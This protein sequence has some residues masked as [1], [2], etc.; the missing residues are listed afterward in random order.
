[1]IGLIRSVR[2]EMTVPPKTR[3]EL[4]CWDP[5]PALRRWIDTWEG[6]F[7]RLANVDPISVAASDGAREKVSQGSIQLFDGASEYWL[8]LAGIIDIPAER[9]RLSGVRDKVLAEAQK[10]AR[11]LENADFVARAKPEVVQENRE[12]LASFQAEAARLEAALARIE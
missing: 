7:Q 3:T 9:K 11:K 4:Y 8:H 2:T 6:Q 1:L 12:R 5:P 10:V